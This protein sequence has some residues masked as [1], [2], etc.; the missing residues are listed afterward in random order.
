MFNT[1]KCGIFSKSKFKA[2]NMIKIVD[3]DLLIFPNL[4]L[5]KIW[6]SQSE[7]LGIFNTFNCGIFSKNPN[8]GPPKWPVLQF[9]I[10]Q[11]CQI[12]FHKKIWASESEYCKLACPWLYIQNFLDLNSPAVLKCKSCKIATVGNT[13]V[14]SIQEW[15]MRKI[16]R[17]Q[18]KMCQL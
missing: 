16:G 6:V 14:Q 10:P 2:S 5:P 11:N 4:F 7:N 12:W 3:F 15:N 8:T 1:L 9:H 18:R 17:L 13:D